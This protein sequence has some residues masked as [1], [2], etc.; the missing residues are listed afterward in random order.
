M[1]RRTRTVEAVVAEVATRGHGVVERRE[2]MR[3]GLSP[4]C[5]DRRVRK[6]ALIEVHRGVYRVGHRAPSIEADY[7]A[8]VLACGDRAVLSGRAAAH[9]WG[10]LRG[11]PPAPE[12]T[13]PTERRVE[14]VVC[15]RCR[16]LETRD[17]VTHRGI[18]VLSVPETVVEMASCLSASALA[19]AFHEAAVRFGTVP[20]E[21]EAVLERR[22]NST[23]AGKLRRVLRGGER[24][25]LSALESRFLELLRGHD[26]P[27]PRTNARFGRRRLDCH[28]PQHGLVVE[29]DSYRFHGSRHAWEE[30]RRRE[31]L[32]RARGDEFRRYTWGDVYE[33][34]ALMLRE[35]RFLLLLPS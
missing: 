18:P 27:L 6:G 31:R 7:R 34:P 28:W 20:A 5:I 26:L 9:L 2:L 19:R 23:G 12:V 35:L 14:G 8:A 10:L 30:D 16:R 1:G 13:A 24:V 29:L 32:V 22:P 11:R 33:S 15:L 3:A 25:T 4:D 21:V 17:R